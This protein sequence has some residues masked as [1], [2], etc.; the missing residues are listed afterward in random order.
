MR[1]RT[2]GPLRVSEVGLGTWLNVGLADQPG[3]DRLV[4]TALD[5]GITLFD[6]ADSYGDAQRALGRAL[7][8]VPREEYVISTKVY[9][10]G[11]GGGSLSRE[12]LLA[13]AGTSLAELGTGHLDLLSA[14]RFDERT[15]L[16]QTIAA[17]GE[18]VAAGTIR[19][20]GVSEWTADQLERACRLAAELGVPAPVADQVQYNVLWRTPQARITAACQRFGLGLVAFGGLA[21]GILTGKYR[22]GAA[23]PAGTR[24][25]SDLGQ[26]TM[27]GLMHDAVLARVELFARVA[28]RRGL[29]AS[30][31]ALAWILDR[32][33][34]SAVL[35]GASSAGQL[36]ENAAASGVALDEAAR[37]L[38]D[39]VFVGCVL[40]GDPREHGDQHG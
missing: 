6:T 30:Q 9:F 14:H 16:P 40:H 25:A 7:R 24:W 32:P 34:V 21:Q 20:Y 11:D 3:A 36:A 17:F 37:T 35:V 31:L 8:G 29:T 10:T 1:Y 38:I 19:H 12:H 28:A 22:P 23:P 4:R 18:L 27:Q 2:A 39:N 13:S 33:A 15:P 5:L 26:L